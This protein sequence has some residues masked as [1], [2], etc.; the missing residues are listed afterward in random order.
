MAKARGR[1]AGNESSQT[2]AQIGAAIARVMARLERL[3]ANRQLTYQKLVGL[4]GSLNARVERFGQEECEAPRR[5]LGRPRR[6][7][8]LPGANRDP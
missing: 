7:L 4:Q 6:S 8:P 3:D 1:S 5:G 2:A